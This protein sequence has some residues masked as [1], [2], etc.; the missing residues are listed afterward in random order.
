[1]TFYTFKSCGI[2]TSG[3]GYGVG[4]KALGTANIGDMHESA[5]NAGKIKNANV[6]ESFF[7]A[8]VFFAFF[9]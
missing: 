1:M 7:V 5:W 8:D 3:R 4:L 6:N 9:F 2:L